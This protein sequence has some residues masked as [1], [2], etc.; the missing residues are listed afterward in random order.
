[1]GTAY[2]RISV[3]EYGLL[4]LI[5]FNSATTRTGVCKIVW[6]FFLDFIQDIRMKAAVSV[7]A[8]NQLGFLCFFILYLEKSPDYERTLKYIQRTL[9]WIYLNLPLASIS[10]SFMSSRVGLADMVARKPFR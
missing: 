2:L 10:Q 7:A 1:M 5:N 3:N 9:I 6:F 8:N 4:S